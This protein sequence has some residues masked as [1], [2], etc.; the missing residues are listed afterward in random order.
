MFSFSA[1]VLYLIC[2]ATVFGNS[3]VVLAVIKVRIDFNLHSI[4][5][6]VYSKHFIVGLNHINRYFR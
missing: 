2:C 1:V 3:L 6:T 4:L 5:T